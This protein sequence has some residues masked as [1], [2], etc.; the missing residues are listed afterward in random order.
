MSFF[1]KQKLHVCLK[2]KIIDI[3][4]HH[5]LWIA[6][7]NVALLGDEN[8]IELRDRSHLCYKSIINYDL[9]ITN[10]LVVS[11]QICYIEVFDITNPRFKEQIW[12]VPS[13][14]VKSRFYCIIFFDNWNFHRIFFIPLKSSQSICSASLPPCFLQ[15]CKLNPVF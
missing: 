2:V 11:P 12:L 15:T 10:I 7:Q 8:Y 1:C 6:S 3:E 4:S 13:D 5:A 14:F 9:D